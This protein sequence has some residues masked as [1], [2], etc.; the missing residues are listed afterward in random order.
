[1]NF[2]IQLSYNKF[3]ENTRLLGVHN[4]SSI[5]N[6]VGEKIDF[7]ICHGLGRIRSGLLVVWRFYGKTQY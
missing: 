3:K 4:E 1:M 7:K 6:S 2:I 5:K